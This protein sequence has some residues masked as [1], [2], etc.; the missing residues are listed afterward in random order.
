MTKHRYRSSIPAKAT[1]RI[2]EKYEDGSTKCV[3]YYLA[4][5]L[6]GHRYWDEEGELY[7]EYGIKNGKKHGREYYFCYP[8]GQPDEMTPYRNGLPHGIAM[9]FNQRGEILITSEMK[10][11]VGL[12]LWCDS[13]NHTLSEEQYY[14]NKN[15]CGYRRNWNEDEKTIYEEYYWLSP[16]GYHGIWR[17]WNESGKLRRGFPRYYI[18]GKQ[19][20]KR[21][22]QADCLQDRSLIP[23][24][25]A[26]DSPIRPLPKQYLAQRKRRK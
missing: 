14:P 22:Y 15:E 5:K 21:S 4:G 23:Y 20:T 13:L 9:Q 18:Q 11:G 19:V 24:R 1:R 12:D 17:E 8:H 6:V 10:K 16:H 3:G 7:L 25:E 26:D 2:K